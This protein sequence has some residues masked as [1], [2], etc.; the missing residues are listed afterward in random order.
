MHINFKAKFFGRF[1]FVLFFFGDI[2]ISSIKSGKQYLR[3]WLRW[4][5]SNS[6]RNKGVKIDV[7]ITKRHGSLEIEK[8]MNSHY[9]LVDSWTFNIAESWFTKCDS[10]K[11]FLCVWPASK[12][13]LFATS[14]PSPLLVIVSSYCLIYLMKVCIHLFCCRYKLMHEDRTN[15]LNCPCT[16]YVTCSRR[17]MYFNCWSVV[18]LICRHLF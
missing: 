7:P 8:Q 15:D 17:N 9:S 2:V 3:L 18:Y 1:H 11:K 10:K 13:N 6:G 16:D 12:S 4:I 5:S 14:I